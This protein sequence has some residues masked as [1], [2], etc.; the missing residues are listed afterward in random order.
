[1]KEKVI[2]QDDPFMSVI[3]LEK[4]RAAFVGAGGIG[5]RP[6][7]RDANSGTGPQAAG[8]EDHP[9]DRFGLE[10]FVGAEA[11]AMQGQIVDHDQMVGA[12]GAGFGGEPAVADEGLTWAAAAVGCA[13]RRR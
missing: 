8:V 7:S 9:V 12:A 3:G 5:I 10:L 2:N 4:F 6:A 11:E 13:G 1:M